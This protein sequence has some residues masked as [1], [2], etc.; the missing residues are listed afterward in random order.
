MCNEVKN[1]LKLA[2]Q[3]HKVA[4]D[5]HWVSKVSEEGPQMS[6]SFVI[7][8][9]LECEFPFSVGMDVEHCILVIL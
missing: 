6:S 2:N 8:L 3:M 5:K 1:N 9:K 4:A 7:R